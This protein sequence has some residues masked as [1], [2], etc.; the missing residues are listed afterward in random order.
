MWQDLHPR[1]KLDL[2]TH[3]T[4]GAD[5]D[6]VI[7]HLELQTE[8]HLQIAVCTFGPDP[9]EKLVPVVHCTYVDDA[10]QS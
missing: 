7:L 3:G 4:L 9:T 10:S 1:P 6:G 5:L 2:C 8:L